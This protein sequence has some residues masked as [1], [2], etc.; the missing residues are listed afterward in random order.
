MAKL[1]VIG[2]GQQMRGDDAA[3]VQAVQKWAAQY[4]E[5]LSGSQVEMALTPLPGLGLLDQ[6]SGYDGA[7]LVDAVIGGPGVTPGGLLQ[8]T[9]KDLAGFSR[10]AGSAH[11]W[12]VAES[13]QLAE[14]MGLDE[15]P[16][17]I[18]I[19]GIG[20]VQVQLGAKLSPEVADAIPKAVAALDR[21]VED[22]LESQR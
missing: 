4:P 3:G 19:L 18:K 20:G 15:I 12:G 21:L 7:I 11:G 5:R 2:I 6:L 22:W 10:G 14:V 17:W 16:D 8:L 1:I 13:F 9:P